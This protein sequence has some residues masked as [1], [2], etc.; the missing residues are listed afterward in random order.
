LPCCTKGRRR[1]T[2]GAEVIEIQIEKCQR[3]VVPQPQQIAVARSSPTPIPAHA[4][5]LTDPVLLRPLLPNVCR[6]IECR[7]RAR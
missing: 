6:T 4:L 7:D 3:G 2:H 1:N 5:K